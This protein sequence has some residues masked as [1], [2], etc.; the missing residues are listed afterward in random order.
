MIRLSNIFSIRVFAVYIPQAK[1]W[2]FD[3]GALRKIAST[4]RSYNQ[5]HGNYV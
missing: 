4:A 2:G 3:G 5:G 1:A